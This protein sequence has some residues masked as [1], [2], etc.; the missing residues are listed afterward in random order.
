[1]IPSW[2]EADNWIGWFLEKYGLPHLHEG[3]ETVI[4]KIQK[5]KSMRKGL[6]GI[7][8]VVVAL[9][10][11]GLLAQGEKAADPQTQNSSPAS[12]EDLKKVEEKL[13]RTLREVE[14]NAAS[15]TEK[16][17]QDAEARHQKELEQRALADKKMEEQAAE[18]AAR[19][20]TELEA[21]QKATAEKIYIAIAFIVVASLAVFLGLY[22]SV[23]NQK[24]KVI[25]AVKSAEPVSGAML[26]NPEIPDLNKFSQ[27]NGGIR[28][29]QTLLILQDNRRYIC[30]AILKDTGEWKALIEGDDT[31]VTWANRRKRAAMLKPMAMA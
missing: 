30:T 4:S 6:A 13:S 16:L 29:F 19:Q 12:A 22:I 7:I 24:V 8:L 9:S 15:R 25:A 17:R 11:I 1:M 18:Y 26:I 31:E 28:E 5:G 14:E 21:A 10:P 3:S 27:E 2:T 20:K 23:R